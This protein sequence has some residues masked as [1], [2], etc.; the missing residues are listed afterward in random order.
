LKGSQLRARPLS[1]EIPKLI[2]P[3]PENFFP[4]PE[5]F[6]G[7]ETFKDIVLRQ[8]E[9][10]KEFPWEYVIFISV[11]LLILA[12]IVVKPFDTDSETSVGD[13]EEDGADESEIVKRKQP[14]TRPPAPRT[15]EEEIIFAMKKIQFQDD[16]NKSLLILGSFTAMA[17]WLAGFLNTPHPFEP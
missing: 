12:E 3:R 7:G 15:K 10:V 14:V 17:L 8:G 13:T 2:F 11:L 5:R 4:R 6:F 16:Q 9:A 1:Y